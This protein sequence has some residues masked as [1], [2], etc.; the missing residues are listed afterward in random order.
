MLEHA[1]GSSIT[2]RLCFN[3]MIWSQTTNLVD[4]IEQ[5]LVELIKLMNFDVSLFPNYMLKSLE[6]ANLAFICGY[7]F[8]LLFN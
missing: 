4:Q 2:L 8:M 3:Y 1:E 6:N 5:L 7:L